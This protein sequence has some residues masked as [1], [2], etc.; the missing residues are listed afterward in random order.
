MRDGVYFNLQEDEYHALPALSASG[1]KNLLVS[2]LDFYM[3]SWMAPAEVRDSEDSFAMILGRAYHKR[4]L[5]GKEAFYKSYA[6]EFVAP[7]GCLKTIEDLK[8][9]LPADVETKKA[10]KK[11]DFIELVRNTLPAAPIYDLLKHDYLTEHDG[12]EFL[13]QKII[14][15][16]EI[17]AAMIEKH[18]EISKCFRGG[19]PEVSV[20]WTEGDVRMK[21]RFDYLKPK[22]VI[23]LKTFGNYQNKPVDA[24]IYAAMASGKYHIQA[25]FYLR[26]VEMAKRLPEWHGIDA[27]FRQRVFECEAHDFFFV[28]QQKGIAP[29]ARAKKFTL[30]GIYG[31]GCAAIEDAIQR[32]KH[33]REKYGEDPWVDDAPIDDFED[34]LFPA[35]TTEL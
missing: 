33:Y 10:K 8:A 2:P 4:I 29:L 20:V 1:I 26:A 23:D 13:S 19:Y 31:A 18:P 17:A 27:G 24:A 15:E 12:K 30:G 6:P 22:A 16:I 34:L 35:Y 11:E 14:A 9:A 21:A 3:R 5:E 32:F 25:A 7:E 28:F